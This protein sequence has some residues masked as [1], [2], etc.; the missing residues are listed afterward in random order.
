MGAL[1]SSGTVEIPEEATKLEIAVIKNSWLEEKKFCWFG[2]LLRLSN[3]HEKNGRGA[4]KICR[5]DF[6]RDLA[7]LDIEHSFQYIPKRKTEQDDSNLLTAKNP[8]TPKFAIKKQEIDS[9]D[10]SEDDY[11]EHNLTF[12]PGD[13]IKIGIE[14]F[15]AMFYSDLCQLRLMIN[16]T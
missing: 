10:E 15:H 6:N 12:N 1:C 3:Y 8:K 13:K 7:T 5:T 4:W 16:L 11:D 9:S 2:A 14:L